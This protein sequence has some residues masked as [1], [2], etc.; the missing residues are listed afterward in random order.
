MKLSQIWHTAAKAVNNF[1]KA[2]EG[3]EHFADKPIYPLPTYLTMRYL[4]SPHEM[5]FKAR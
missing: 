1:F 5:E 4:G 2:P 3:W